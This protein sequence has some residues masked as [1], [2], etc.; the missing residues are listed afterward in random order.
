M[1][2]GSAFLA[3]ANN[4]V[5]DCMVTLAA[6]ETTPSS[7]TAAASVT[8]PNLVISGSVDCTAP[9][10]THQT[11]MYNALAS[12]CKVFISIIGGCHCY[13][14]NYN[15]TCTLGESFCLPVPPLDRTAQQT[16]VMNFVVPY[17]DYWLNGN[18]ASWNFFVDS[19]NASSNITFIN[20]CPI[21][22]EAVNE[23][24]QNIKMDVYPNPTSDN[25]N[26]N[27]SQIPEEGKLQLIDITGRIL[28]SQDLNSLT[29]GN[30]IELNTKDLSDG[31]YFIKLNRKNETLKTQRFIK[32]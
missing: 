29:S 32:M 10:A 30:E 14:A 1:G 24:S 13:F 5:P 25:V 7:T 26:I 19:L 18:A 15:F 31:I 17:L 6:A 8:I 9:A 22:P 27:I 3:C 4:T 21:V 20:D 2:G 12:P 11:P 16:T 28:L 23:I